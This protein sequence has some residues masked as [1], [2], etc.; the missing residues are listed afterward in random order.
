MPQP[1]EISF[2]P[3]RLV[4]TDMRLFRGDVPIELRP[5]A[6][7]VLSTLVA[8]A[9]Q[10]VTK[11]QLIEAV[12]PD[13]TVGDDVL[14]GCVRE[15]REAL[16]DDSAQPRFI[17]TAHRRGYRFIAP[18]RAAEPVAGGPE[19]VVPG[20]APVA[21]GPAPVS[22]APLC[23]GREDELERLR[24]A[25][26]QAR[27]GVRRCVF[28]VGEAGSGKTTLIGRFLAQ[29]GARVL[30]G[31]CIDQFGSSEPLLPILDALAQLAALEP[32][33]AALLDRVAP[34]WRPAG[35]GGH[36]G[37]TATPSSTLRALAD[38][39]DALTPAHGLVLVI[40]DMHWCDHTTLALVSLLCTRP[41][42][43]ALLVVGS[44]RPLVPGGHPALASTVHELEQRGRASRVS[45][46]GLAPQAVERL[47]CARLAA[48]SALPEVSAL[49]HARTGGSPMFVDE[50]AT[51]LRRCGTLRVRDG[52]IVPEPSLDEV[53]RTVPEGLRSMIAFSLARRDAAQRGVLEVLALAAVP[54]P[55]AVVA[56]IV[57]G[58]VL[59][60]E[61]LC[62]RLCEP[63]CALGRET[64]PSSGAV[65]YAP[66][67]ALF[68]DVV[69]E[70]VPPER[71]ALLHGQL[72][73]ALA[74]RPEHAGRDASHVLALHLERARQ[75][76]EAARWLAVAAEHAGER[77]A[78]SE[79]LALAERG[80]GL[81]ARV[82][83][84]DRVAEDELRLLLASGHALVELQGFGSEA[85]A[86]TF[87]RARPLAEAIADDERRAEVLLGLRAYHA[88]RDLAV[89]FGLCEQVRAIAER[90]GH[91]GLLLQAHSA[92]GD[93]T[94]CRGALEQAEAHYARAEALTHALL[95]RGVPPERLGVGV[96]AARKSLSRHIRGYPDQ[97]AALI[98]AA[99]VDPG[100]CA[101]PFQRALVLV[102]AGF[103]Y[104]MR[105]QPEVAAGHARTALELA[106]RDGF[107]YWTAAGHVI[108][109][110]S[111]AELGAL[112]PGIE[113]MRRGI[114][115]W[116]AIGARV[117]HPTFVAELGLALAKR[118]GI[119]EALA[120]LRDAREV[121]HESGEAVLLAELLRLE[122]EWVMDRDASRSAGLLDQAL[123]TAR[124]QGARAFELR[125]LTTR[126]VYEGRHGTPRGREATRRALAEAC[127]RYD[128][129]AELPDLRDARAALAGGAR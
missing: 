90:L 60:A 45:L 27:S 20:P 35:D 114:A 82:P 103:L 43:S 126:L 81:L 110:S 1:H 34:R 101:D 109:G 108:L 74:A 54:L 15:L 116:R 94:F 106:E 91:P 38:A 51:E 17:Q 119:D 22:T 89:A 100:A 33:T 83:A 117:L 58:D 95:A 25:L 49:L 46:A 13:V 77:H 53:A 118:G 19:P 44:L 124:A 92:L 4:M 125:T 113:H 63:P 57:Q 76:A 36:A 105:R 5:K 30:Q 55:A 9:G 122:G 41:S 40:E 88:M 104:L 11:Q 8:H 121:A 61:Q 80:L 23:V 66:V 79:S 62:E 42:R 129:G 12:W 127:A 32:E 14:K 31:Q 24:G 56:A 97:A 72:A 78:P 123:V 18:V 67:H 75:P 64:N 26:E 59:E 115:L 69:A 87:E 3:Y 52:V 128:E 48:R 50:L 28:L 70:T 47:L 10:L 112:D 102:Y 6:F 65:G 16:G 96:N 37:P 21:G 2:P 84:A 107:R 85:L 120:Q 93:N 7:A 39:L 86:R 98:D 68:R 71:A 29:A 111:M 73:R 99:L